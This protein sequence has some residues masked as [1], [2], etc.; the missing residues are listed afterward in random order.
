MTG[1]SAAL[2]HTKQLLLYGLFLMKRL[3]ASL[4]PFSLSFRTTNK[5][6]WPVLADFG[7]EKEEFFI[8]LASFDFRSGKGLKYSVICF[9]CTSGLAWFSCNVSL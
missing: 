5:K 7:R 8:S 9:L 1:A 4:G 3:A 2:H 6:I